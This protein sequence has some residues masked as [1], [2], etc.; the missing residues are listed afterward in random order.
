MY[1]LYKKTHKSRQN[2][3]FIKI[4]ETNELGFNTELNEL[5]D[6]S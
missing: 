4:K 3:E 1:W 5:S 2:K 6:S